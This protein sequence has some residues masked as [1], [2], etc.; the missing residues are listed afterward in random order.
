MRRSLAGWIGSFLLIVV[1]FAVVALIAGTYLQSS[2]LSPV[3]SE[4]TQSTTWSSE[5]LY[6][7]A[8]D[9]TAVCVVEP[10]NGE[11]RFIVAPSRPGGRVAGLTGAVVNRWFSGQATVTCDLPVMVSQQPFSIGFWL[12]ERGW[13]VI[14]GIILIAVGWNLLPNRRARPTQPELPGCQIRASE[15]QMGDDQH[16]HHRGGLT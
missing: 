4:D 11:K 15:P 1:G 13:P 10:V 9:E 5:S 14:P 12:A 6:L 2:L 8:L 7:N 16:G 3:I